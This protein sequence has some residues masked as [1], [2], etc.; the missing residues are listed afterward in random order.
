MLYVL[1]YQTFSQDLFLSIKIN[2]GHLISMKICLHLLLLSSLINGK[3]ISVSKNCFKVNFSM[4][5]YQQVFDLYTYF[6]YLHS[7]SYVKILGWKAIKSGRSSISRCPVRAQLSEIWGYSLLTK[8]NH[9]SHHC[10]WSTSLLCVKS[11]PHS[12]KKKGIFFPQTS[13]HSIVLGFVK[14]A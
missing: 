6:M 7:Q 11:L 10:P 5:Y 12:N 8:H 9:I 4:I 2:L 1:L 13:P 3:I 14:M